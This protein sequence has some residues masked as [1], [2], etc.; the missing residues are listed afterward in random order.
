MSRDYLPPTGPDENR[1]GRLKQALSLPSTVS[2]TGYLPGRVNR[3]NHHLKFYPLLWN[4]PHRSHNQD[5]RSIRTE[6]ISLYTFHFSATASNIVERVWPLKRLPLC[7]KLEAGARSW[8][9]TTKENM[10]HISRCNVQTSGYYHACLCL[11]TPSSNLGFDL[12]LFLS[13]IIFSIR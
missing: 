8:T 7:Y 1:P 9:G 4:E 6:T 11:C 13:L 10:S 5:E 12:L 2:R 3:L